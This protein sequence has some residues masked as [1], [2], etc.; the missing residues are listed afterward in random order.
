LTEEEEEREEE[1]EGEGDEGDE[2]GEE[3]E[4]PS[5]RGSSRRSRALPFPGLRRPGGPVLRY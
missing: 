3:E 4:E 2:E 1:R 5:C